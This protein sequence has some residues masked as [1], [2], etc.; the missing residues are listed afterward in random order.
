MLKRLLQRSRLRRFWILFVSSIIVTCIVALSLV[1]DQQQT[2]AQTGG[3]CQ[4][5][6]NAIAQK[7]QLRLAALKGDPAAQQQYQALARQHGQQVQA[8][9]QQQWP[10]K[11]AIWLRL[12]PC[13]VRPGELNRIFD[14]IVNTG[15]N[16]VYVEMFYD[17]RVL[18]PAANNPTVWPSVVSQPGL[19]NVDLLEQA[20]QVG[21]QRGLDVYAWLFTLN[22]GYTYSLRPDRQTAI[23]LNGSGQTSLD[24]VPD[25]TPVFVDPYSPEARRD[26]LQLIREVQRYNP[27]GVLFDYVRFPRG[28]G[29]ASIVSRVQD[30]FIHN[31]AARNAFLDRAQNAK[32]RALLQQFIT[33]GFVG[34]YDIAT[35]NNQYPGDPVP[36]WE[37][38]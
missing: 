34:S 23:A 24:V 36:L 35:V 12:Y 38:S 3:S 30:L 1:T 10:R 21:R 4:I 5:P 32:G 20:L 13:D 31:A 9:R 22:F 16:Q 6:P 8:C 15:Y 11:Q 25:S 7:E 17:G 29:T 26:Y 2:L 18:L 19:E 27:D 37:N 28:R 33:K 14:Q